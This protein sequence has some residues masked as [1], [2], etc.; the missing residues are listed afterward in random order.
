L[1][2]YRRREDSNEGNLNSSEMLTKKE[3]DVT[4][5]PNNADEI[6]DLD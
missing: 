1:L 5:D 6:Y 3:T 4:L 2:F